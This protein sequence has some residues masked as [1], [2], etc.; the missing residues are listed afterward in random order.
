MNSKKLSKGILFL[1][2]ALVL[3]TISQS[4]GQTQP[5]IVSLST[6]GTAGQGLNDTAVIQKALYSTAVN[7]QTLEIPASREPYKVGPLF[8]PN[9]SNILLDADVTVRATPGYTQNQRL[10]SIS[11]VN[12]VTIIGTPGRSIFQMLKAEYTSGEYRHC[13]AI[14]GANNVNISGIECNDSGGD[15]LYISGGSQGYSSNINVVNSTFNN[16]R[17]Q[18]LSLISGRH[19]TISNCRFTHTAGTAPSDGIDMEPNLPADSLQDIIIENSSAIGNDGNGVVF[20]LSNL[21]STSQPVSV[22]VSNFMSARNK[23]SGYFAANGQVNGAPEVTGTVLVSDSTSDTDGNYG[24]VASYWDVGGISL[25]FQNLKVLN[26]NQSKTNID[27]A[28]IAI[29]RGGGDRNY[30]G[31]VHFFGTSVIDTDGNV[32]VYFTVWDWSKI[33]IKQVQFLN[34]GQLLGAKLGTGLFQGKHAIT[35]DEF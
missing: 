16:N 19:V 24:A 32:D 30:M 2:S 5:K 25:T 23:G 12:N 3:P 15:G 10:L 29:K 26:V 14:T 33:G 28:A 4:W 7:G 21:N 34:P 27:N 20:A 17:R 1:L 8:I 6:F 35:L 11:E 22:R 31:N 13:L 18:G 9:N